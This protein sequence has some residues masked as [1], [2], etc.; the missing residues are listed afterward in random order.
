L[1]LQLLCGL[2]GRCFIQIAF[3]VGVDLAEGV[4]EFKDLLLIKLRIFPW[5]VS[6]GSVSK[7]VM[8]M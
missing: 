1:I 5:E 7:V 6:M 2:D 8:P 4:L 3:V